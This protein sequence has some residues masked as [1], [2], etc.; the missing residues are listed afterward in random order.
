MIDLDIPI[1]GWIQGIFKYIPGEFSD[2]KLV[3]S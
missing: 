3:S 2:L 1:V